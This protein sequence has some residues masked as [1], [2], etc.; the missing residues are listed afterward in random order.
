MGTTVELS[1]ETGLG[2]PQCA[3]SSTAYKERM[4]NFKINETRRHNEKSIN[5]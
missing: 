1:Q 3:G 4:K 5:L 2:R